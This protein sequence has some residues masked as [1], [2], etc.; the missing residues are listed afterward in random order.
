MVGWCA[1]NRV[2]LHII[3]YIYIYIAEDNLVAVAVLPFLCPD[4]RT[5]ASS[6]KVLYFTKVKKF[7]L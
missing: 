2:C 6:E 1:F 7:K 3:M 4:V 5:S